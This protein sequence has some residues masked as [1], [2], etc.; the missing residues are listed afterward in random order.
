M[1]CV[2]IFWDGVSYENKSTN[3]LNNTSELFDDDQCLTAPVNQMEVNKAKA[4]GLWMCV[5]DARATPTD[6]LRSHD[7]TAG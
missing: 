1:K 2:V 4:A 5:L 3:D 6:G 7:L